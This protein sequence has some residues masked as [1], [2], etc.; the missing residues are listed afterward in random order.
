MLAYPDYHSPSS[1][2]TW[3]N[4]PVVWCLRY[5]WDW[6]DSGPKMWRGSAIEAGFAAHL[7]GVH[8]DAAL[9]IALLRYGNEAA[10]E[11][12]NEIQEQEKLIEPMLKQL[13]SWHERYPL[14][15]AA[16]Q[17]EII[18][19]LEGVER[20][21][22]GFVDFAFMQG[23][24]VDTKTTEAC[25]SKPRPDDLRQVAVYAK[26]RER[27]QALLYATDKKHAFF[28]PSQDELDAA[29]QEIVAAAR[30]LER[31]LSVMPDRETALRCL[32]HNDHFTFNQAAKAKLM[33][34]GA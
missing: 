8:F 25:P 9:E 30:S 26:G 7:R 33:E 20:P 15:L 28:N 5:L 21:L 24:D 14:E 12:T 34:I 27:P 13:T 18:T 23:L 17:I 19:Y 31:F 4:A 11:I 16:T 1:L 22:R 32:P 2:K 3:R 10:G 6:R 29:L